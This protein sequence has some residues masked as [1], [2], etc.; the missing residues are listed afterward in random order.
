MTPGR[1]I[2]ALAIVIAVFS[3][4]LPAYPL[5]TIAVILIGI[6]MFVP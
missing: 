1:W 2:A 5:L 6:C 3:L 4:V